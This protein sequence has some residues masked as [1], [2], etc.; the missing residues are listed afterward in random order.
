MTHEKER[1][2]YIFNA[3]IFSC[4]FIHIWLN[5]QI[6]S[7]QNHRNNCSQRKLTEE[8]STLFTSILNLMNVDRVKLLIK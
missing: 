7:L 5:L 3:K 2:M 6:Q 8:D 4:I 1:R